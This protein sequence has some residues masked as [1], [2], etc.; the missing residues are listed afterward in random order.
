MARQRLKGSIHKRAGDGLWVATIEMPSYGTTRRRKVRYAKTRKEA[1]SKLD[2]LRAELAEAPDG[3]LATTTPTVAG[4]V[5]AYLDRM[6]ADPGTARST[7]KTYR[8]RLRC[9]VAPV[10]GKVRLDEL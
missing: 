5:A 3:D 2:A 9:D 4:W 6:A 7:V 8:S 10:I 1:E